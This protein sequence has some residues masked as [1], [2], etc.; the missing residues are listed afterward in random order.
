MYEECSHPEILI[1][2]PLEASLLWL[3][4]HDWEDDGVSAQLIEG[5]DLCVS[6]PG[7]TW[8]RLSV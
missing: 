4:F 2:L 1:R 3:W 5:R 7:G 6:V 8:T